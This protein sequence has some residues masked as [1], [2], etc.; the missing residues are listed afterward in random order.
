MPTSSMVI[1]A[2]ALVVAGIFVASIGARLIAELLIRLLPQS[3]LPPHLRAQT[4]PDGAN[5]EDYAD[6]AN[7]KD[8]R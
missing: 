7:G 8:N 4:E 1:A 3:L 6:L 2:F 5:Y